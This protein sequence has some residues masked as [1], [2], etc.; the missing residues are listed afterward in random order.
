[1]ISSAE[2]CLAFSSPAALPL[3]HARGNRFPAGFA[4]KPCNQP[5]FRTLSMEGIS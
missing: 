5:L 3:R 2:I 1:M 4:V